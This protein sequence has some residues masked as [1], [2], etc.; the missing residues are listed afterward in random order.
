MQQ[1]VDLYVRTV[2][3]EKPEKKPEGENEESK[4]PAP[5]AGEKP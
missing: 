4:T 1:D 3:Q 2:V 5:L